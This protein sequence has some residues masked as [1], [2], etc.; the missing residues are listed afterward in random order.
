MEP[1]FLVLLNPGIHVGTKEAY[2]GVSVSEDVIAIEEVVQKPIEQWKELLK[3]DF[4]TSVFQRHPEIEKLKELPSEIKHKYKILEKTGYILNDSLT[5][6]GTLA[7]EIYEGNPLLM[8]YAYNKKLFHK[9]S[10]S[11]ISN[12]PVNALV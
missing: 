8:S 7:A 3:N 2:D 11:N 5:M 12:Q 9:Y 10:V 6:M 4:E 1:L